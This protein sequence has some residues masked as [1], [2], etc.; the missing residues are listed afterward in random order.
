VPPHPCSATVY[1][2]LRIIVLL[3]FY[4]ISP[5]K[6]KHFRN[7][8]PQI[9]KPGTKP[10]IQNSPK[11]LMNQVSTLALALALAL[12]FTFAFPLENNG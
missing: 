4:S 9:Q 11:A 8:L 5:Q 7:T 6:S 2:L 1:L 3:L 12:T 10:G